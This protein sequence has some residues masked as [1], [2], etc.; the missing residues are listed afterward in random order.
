MKQK[1]ETILEDIKQADD[2]EI[3]EIVT[4][5]MD[6]YREVYPE[7]EIMYLAVPKNNP[8][9]RKRILEQAFNY[10]KRYEQI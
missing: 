2:Y 6:R 8:E 9:E 7:W 3:Y 10:L 5:A 4:A 1:L